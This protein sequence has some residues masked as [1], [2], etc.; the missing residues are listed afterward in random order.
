MLKNKLLPAFLLL[1]GV[2]NLKVQ[3]LTFGLR[4]LVSVTRQ[5]DNEECLRLFKTHLLDKNLTRITI[6]ACNL[7][8]GTKKNEPDYEI[9]TPLWEFIGI[10]HKIIKFVED[11]E[12]VENFNLA[13]TAQYCRIITDKILT[14]LNVLDS[15]G[16]LE[17]DSLM[18]IDLEDLGLEIFKI[19]KGEESSDAELVSTQTGSDGQGIKRTFSAAFSRNDSSFSTSSLGDSATSAISLTQSSD[20][21]SD[22]IVR[23]PS[24]SVGARPPQPK[25]TR[26]PKIDRTPKPTLSACQ[27]RRNAAVKQGASLIAKGNLN[28][29][30]AFFS[31]P[32]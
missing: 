3:A 30:T 1:F 17:T 4:E 16:L 5:Q 29:I 28:P 11:I 21:D 12:P 10:S 2:T 25:N 14:K 9:V 6:D 23:T 22:E 24:F 13:A 7:R 20:F 15:D 27:K 19:L 32:K 8:R 18:Q 26:K 31:A